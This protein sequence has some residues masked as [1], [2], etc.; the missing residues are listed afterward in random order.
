[1]SLKSTLVAAL[2]LISLGAHAIPPVPPTVIYNKIRTSAAQN[3]QTV[4]G[5][6]TVADLVDTKE[7]KFVL[8][9]SKDGR[10]GILSVIENGKLSENLEVTCKQ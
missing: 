5:D 6:I 9:L 2:A 10:A 4:R 3:C 8:Q 7:V 1:M